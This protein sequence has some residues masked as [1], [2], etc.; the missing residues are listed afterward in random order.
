MDVSVI[1]PA[2]N[3]EFLWKTVNCVIDAARADTEVI[4]VYDG[5]WPPFALN[6]H[7]RVRVIHNT[8]PV[9]QRAACNDAVAVSRA[10]YVMKL[11][12]HCKVDDGFDTKL[13]ADCEYDWTVMPRMYVL[14]AFHW[15]CAQCGSESGQG[16]KPDRCGN[17]GFTVMKKVDV[18]QPKL[19]KVTDYMWFDTDLKIGYFDRNAGITGKNKRRLHHKYRQWANGDVTDVMCGVGACWFMHRER[20]IELGGMDERHGSWGQMAV[21]VAC[22]AWLSGGRHVV[23]KKT[24][25][26]HLFRTQ[27]GFSWPYEN[28]AHAQER[29]R[30]YSRDLWLNNKWQDRLYNID[31]MIKKFSPVLTWEGYCG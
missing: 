4:V 28:P 18:W 17:C 22:K 8:V 16:P 1:I 26:A 23:N 30:E 21:E 2:R 12:A 10:Q 19:H 11:D 24:W 20:Y 29:A 3:E 7:P 27:K 14:D 5:Y 13:M 31:W 6:E 9:G 15:C 25:F